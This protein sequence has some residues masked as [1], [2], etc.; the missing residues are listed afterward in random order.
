MCLSNATW[1]GRCQWTLRLLWAEPFKRTSEFAA[2][3]EASLSV[4]V[5]FSC[6]ISLDTSSLQWDQY[7]ESLSTPRASFEASCEIGLCS[8][9][10]LEM[11]NQSST[12]MLQWDQNPKHHASVVCV[13]TLCKLIDKRN[14]EVVMTWTIDLNTLTFKITKKTYFKD[15]FWGFGVWILWDQRLL[16][17]YSFFTITAQ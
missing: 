7:Q 9:E 2:S 3:C 15:V 12:A 5:I 13:C 16:C 11:N 1:I 8:L 6:E 14:T 4:D 17:I 10:I